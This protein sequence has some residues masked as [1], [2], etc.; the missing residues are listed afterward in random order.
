MQNLRN[1]ADIKLIKFYHVMRKS[2]F[3]QGQSFNYQKS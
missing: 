3:M 1:I 2:D